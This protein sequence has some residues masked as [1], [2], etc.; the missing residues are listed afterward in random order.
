MPSPGNHPS[1][2]S[3]FSICKTFKRLC[4]CSKTSTLAPS[5]SSLTI[6]FTVPPLR[7]SSSE[8]SWSRISRSICGQLMSFTVFDRS[9]YAGLQ[10]K[11]M[12]TYHHRFE[13]DLAIQDSTFCLKYIHM[14]YKQCPMISAAMASR[15][16]EPR[17]TSK[18]SSVREVGVTYH[19]RFNFGFL[20]IV[21]GT[22]A[23]LIIVAW[24]NAGAR[25]GKFARDLSNR[26][27]LLGTRCISEILF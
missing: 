19:Q 1:A 10:P 25:S 2:D 13:T 16:M 5:S 3:P 24:P 21:R 17:V 15:A 9:R 7:V 23:L 12:S 11:R 14:S 8:S 20:I 26:R 4:H 27:K 18:W 22:R 6:V